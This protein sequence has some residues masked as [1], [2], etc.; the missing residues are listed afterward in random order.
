MV[1]SVDLV[2]LY[3][4]PACII[5]SSKTEPGLLVI[6]LGAVS[7]AGRVCLVFIGVNIC[8]SCRCCAAGTWIRDERRRR[9]LTAAAHYHHHYCCRGLLGEIPPSR[10]NVPVYHTVPWIRS[11]TQRC[12]A[13]TC[14]LTTLTNEWKRAVLHT[15]TQSSYVCGH[16][17]IHTWTRVHTDTHASSPT[18]IIYTLTH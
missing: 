10:E 9:A 6:P 18:L 5:I 8:S 13:I 4:E 7:R 16:A 15:H 17:Q 14:R 3:S 1:S 2:G 12:K 11:R